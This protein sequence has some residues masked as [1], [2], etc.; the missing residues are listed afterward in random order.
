MVGGRGE[1]IACQ[2]DEGTKEE[3]TALGCTT[4]QRGCVA[5]GYLVDWMDRRPS[6][7]LHSVWVEEGW[8]LEECQT[9][10]G[11]STKNLCTEMQL[12]VEG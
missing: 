11:S 8:S 7:T 1:S 3:R 10:S 4:H 12:R 5:L 6:I 9:S 2:V